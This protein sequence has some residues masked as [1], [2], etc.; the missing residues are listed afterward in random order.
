MTDFLKLD[1]F[2]I[3]NLAQSRNFRSPILKVKGCWGW[4]S[5]RLAIYEN[6]LL[7]QCILDIFQL[8]FSLKIWNNSSIRGLGPCPHLATPLYTSSFGEVTVGG[9][10]NEL[11]EAACAVCPFDG[12]RV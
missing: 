11:N 6:V 9:V 12:Y 4:D 5:H 8:K 1:F 2:I 7:K 3:H 10:A